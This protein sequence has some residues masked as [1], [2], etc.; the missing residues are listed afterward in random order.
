MNWN[1][2]GKVNENGNGGQLAIDHNSFAALDE[3]MNLLVDNN[4]D[5]EEDEDEE[6]EEG[7]EE[8]A[9]RSKGNRNRVDAESKAEADIE[10]QGRGQGTGIGPGTGYGQGRGQGQGQRPRAF[11][12]PYFDYYQAH[13]FQGQ[14]SGSRRSINNENNQEGEEDAYLNRAWCRVEMMYATHIP[15]EESLH[16]GNSLLEAAFKTMIEAAD[17]ES[18][19]DEGGKPA[20]NAGI[21]AQMKRIANK[22]TIANK[23]ISDKNIDS[24]CDS[25]S[26][27]MSA[28]GGDDI[29][30]STSA[31]YRRILNF[32]GG[33]RRMAEIG[34]RPVLLYGTMEY[35]NQLPVK[36]LPPLS[37]NF[38]IDFDPMQG[39]LFVSDRSR[40]T[41]KVQELN[42]KIKELMHELQP[43]IEAN[44]EG[45][46]LVGGSARKYT[47]YT[48]E[49]DEKGKRHGFGKV[50]YVMVK[51]IDNLVYVHV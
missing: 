13:G 5:E 31:S 46:G 23:S 29:T 24:K 11:T 50:L 15:T 39:N 19:D 2:K 20:I 3:T 27:S 9:I 40:S 30:T 44:G 14:A 10:G 1:G 41:G 4:H 34:R 32:S 45:G 25:N 36:L 28:I 7:G 35:E 49:R 33:L 51:K 12:K 17:A 47:Q 22:S 6:D 18:S 8:E 37:Q 48:G 43:F 38:A 16:M 42:T 26:N 21:G